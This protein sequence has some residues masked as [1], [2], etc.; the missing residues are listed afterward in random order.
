MAGERERFSAC[1]V[2]SFEGICGRAAEPSNTLYVSLDVA[3][4]EMDLEVM[5]TEFG[6]RLFSTDI[7]PFVANGL[8][9]VGGAT[10]VGPGVAPPVLPMASY[11]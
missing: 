7:P 10:G 1:L 8:W 11:S 3:F 9:M 2:N 6:I 5:G 4:D